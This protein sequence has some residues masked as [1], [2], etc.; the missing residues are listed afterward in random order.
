MSPV[1]LSVMLIHVS[2]VLACLL[3]LLNVF[4][5]IVATV[6]VDTILISKK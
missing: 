4:L 5:I 1:L 3:Q 2:P 6:L